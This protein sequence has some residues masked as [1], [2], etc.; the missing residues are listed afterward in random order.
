MAEPAARQELDPE[1]DHAGLAREYPAVQAAHTVDRTEAVLEVDRMEPVAH[2]EP[3]ADPVPAVAG[4]IPLVDS[5][6]GMRNPSSAA[7]PG[8]R[9]VPLWDRPH[10]H[11]SRAR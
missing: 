2:R 9:G 5:Q 3:E 6:V 1:A 10:H 11:R 7:S 4:C 8:R